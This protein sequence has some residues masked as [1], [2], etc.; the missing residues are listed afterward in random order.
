MGGSV[1]GFDFLGFFFSRAD[2]DFMRSSFGV[3]GP[4][5]LVLFALLLPL[6]LVESLL[7]LLLR[8]SLYGIP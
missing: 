5:V 6:L 1:F 2:G 7:L 8:K 4:I 3:L